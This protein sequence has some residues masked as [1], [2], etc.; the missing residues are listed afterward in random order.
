MDNTSYEER[1]LAAN[2]KLLEAIRNIDPLDPNA[3]KLYAR[4]T[5]LYHELNE[6]IKM[7]LTREDEIQKN[8]IER[9][10]IKSEAN[11]KAEAIKMERERTASES[12]TE[13]RKAY[14]DFFGKIMIA[15]ASIFAAISQIWMFKRSTEKEKD[16]AILT[17]TDQTIVR[18][19]LSGRFFD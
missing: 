9:E 12:K 14:F 19:G 6:D 5:K 8:K 3:E 1:R 15:A 4:A 17:Q 7:H 16:E 2:E 11:T 13:K 10:K 18:N